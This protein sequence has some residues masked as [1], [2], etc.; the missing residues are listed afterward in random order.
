MFLPQ[1]AIYAGSYGLHFFKDLQML[2]KNCAAQDYVS[3]IRSGITTLLALFLF[4]LGPSPQFDGAARKPEGHACPPLVATELEDGPVPGLNLP[5]HLVARLRLRLHHGPLFPAASRRGRAA[6]APEV[7][8]QLCFGKEFEQPTQ[9]SGRQKHPAGHQAPT[10]RGSRTWSS[11]KKKVKETQK[12]TKY[13]FFCTFG[14][15]VNPNICQS[16]L[17]V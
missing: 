14:Y 1:R 13:D 17:L 5:Q 3:C 2:R 4:P 10:H 7:Q 9:V 16:N 12:S 15:E 8:R 11:A 6:E